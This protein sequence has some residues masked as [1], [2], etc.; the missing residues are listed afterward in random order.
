[1]GHMTTE[2]AP[3]PRTLFF[4][5]DGTLVEHGF[6]LSPAVKDAIRKARAAGHLAFICTGRSEVDVQPYIRA[7]GFDGEITN[8]GAFAKVG[9]ESVLALSMPEEQAER[10][11]RY[12]TGRNI[13][14]MVQTIG[15]TYADQRSVDLTI[16]HDQEVRRQMRLAA[17]N[18]PDVPVEGE[19]DVPSFAQWAQTFP[20]LEEM[21]L[22]EVVKVIIVSDQVEDLDEIQSD[23]GEEFQVIQG[24]MPLAEGSSAEIHVAGVT[25][26]FAI[27]K[28]VE[29]LGLDIADSVGIGDSWNDL[30]MFQITGQGVAMGNADPELKKYA[31]METESVHDD[32]VAV[33]L[34]TLGLI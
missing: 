25:K 29:H 13:G 34:Q 3:R 17:G 32:G 23:L 21:Y 11:I 33:A 14:V 8:G 10:L 18:D 7:I 15:D 4:D 26:G 1:M 30:E 24:S 6:P 27:E 5:V 20:R 31:D 28:V 2:T 9:E 12:F 22:S 19:D 16:L